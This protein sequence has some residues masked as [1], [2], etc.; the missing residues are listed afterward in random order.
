MLVELSD[1]VFENDFAYISCNNG[2]VI[3]LN[4]LEEA[5]E[6][7]GLTVP[8]RNITMAY[9]DIDDAYIDI[10]QAIGMS[11]KYTHLYSE[12][13]EQEGKLLTV[14]NISLCKLEVFDE[15]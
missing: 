6:V 1:V 7:D 13:K 12:Y 11:N 2:A 3:V 8:V 14:D 15:Q 4:K 10:T 5:M 9:L